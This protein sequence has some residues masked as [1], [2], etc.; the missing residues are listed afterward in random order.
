LAIPVT[1][2]DGWLGIRAWKEQSSD[3]FD[4]AI[5]NVDGTLVAGTPASSAS[6]SPRSRLRSIKTDCIGWTFARLDAPQ[7]NL[8]ILPVQTSEARNSVKLNQL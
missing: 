3:F 1:Q 4:E 6:T 7:K 2:L 5:L 8:V